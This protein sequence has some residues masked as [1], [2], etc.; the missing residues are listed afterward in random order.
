MACKNLAAKYAEELG[1][2][3][4]EA[5]DPILGTI[6]PRTGESTG[7]SAWLLRREWMCRDKN[8]DTPEKLL[9]SEECDELIRDL[10]DGFGPYDGGTEEK[11]KGL[12]LTVLHEE[13]FLPW[14]HERGLKCIQRVTGD[15]VQYNSETITVPVEGGSDRVYKPGTYL[16]PGLDFPFPE[17]ACQQACSKLIASQDTC[18]ECIQSHLEGMSRKRIVEREVVID[19]ECEPYF[20]DGQYVAPSK[21]IQEAVLCEE[22]IGEH[23]FNLL[24]PLKE[25]GEVDEEVYSEKEFNELWGCI[26]GEFSNELSTTAI[27]AIAVVGGLILIAVIAGSL[28]YVTRKRKQEAERINR[29]IL[30]RGAVR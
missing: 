15:L 28:W 4:P 5:T 19:R 21:D 8:S 30:T 16:D 13:G 3:I 2:G 23:Y 24:K 18:Y 29:Q 1:I 22:C 20:V 11:R 10:V 27:I 7:R 25:N 9:Q 17:A 12:P 14:V 6:N 26:T